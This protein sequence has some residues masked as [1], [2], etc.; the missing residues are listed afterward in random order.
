M[1]HQRN[2]MEKNAWLFIGLLL[3]ILACKKDISGGPD[4]YQMLIHPN[5]RLDLSLYQNIP[6]GFPQF[7]DYQ[8]NSGTRSVAAYS[9]YIDPRKEVADDELTIQLLF[10]FDP[11]VSNFTLQDSALWFANC[12]YNELC[13][14]GLRPAYRIASG[15]ITGQKLDNSTWEFDVAIRYQDFN[16]SDS[17]F[18]EKQFQIFDQFKVE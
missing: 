17:S 14:C 5:S 2:F 1:L 16:L 6:A 7:W 10:E 9:H 8:L 15:Q 18:T 13:Y 12:L 3:V 11:N 4:Q